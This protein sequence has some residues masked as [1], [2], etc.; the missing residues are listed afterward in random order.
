MNNLGVKP[1]YVGAA[2]VAKAMAARGH[3]LL[4][5]PGSAAADA[6][7]PLVGGLP[8]FHPPQ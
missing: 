8:P 1:T 3:S 6:G 2:A 5:Q 7:P 4:R